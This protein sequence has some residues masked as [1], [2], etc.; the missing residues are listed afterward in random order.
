MLIHAH[1]GLSINLDTIVAARIGTF[2]VCDAFAHMQTRRACGQS[3]T[4]QQSA[5]Q[6]VVAYLIGAI[7]WVTAG[8][9]SAEGPLT[10]AGGQLEPV[11]WSE[12]A[13]WTADDH[14]AA[15]AA[16]RNSCDALRKLRR[17][18]DDRGQISRALQNVCRKAIGVRLQDA[19]T[20]RDFEQNFQ[21]V[22][23]AR[24]GRARDS[25]RLLR[26]DCCGLALSA[27]S[28][29]SRSIAGPVIWSQPATSKAARIPEQG[30]D[31]SSQREQRVGAVP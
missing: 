24:L 27:P 12:L 17:T 15:F 5:S 30:S 20:A 9:A 18:D 23:I 22:R 29:L 2:S 4:H 8:T 7:V 19:H 6:G 26:A 11:K 10:L 28:S 3:R 31:R 1:I 13:G 21:P 25:D 14:L 16:Y